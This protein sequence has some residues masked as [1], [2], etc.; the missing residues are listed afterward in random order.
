MFP[1]SSLSFESISESFL[2]FTTNFSISFLN[3]KDN[4]EYILPFSFRF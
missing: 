2:N 4:F 1:L 3:D